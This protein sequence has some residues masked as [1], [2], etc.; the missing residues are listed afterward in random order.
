MIRF[1]YGFNIPKNMDEQ[2]KNELRAHGLLPAHLDKRVLTECQAKG[3][4]PSTL[5]THLSPGTSNDVAELYFAIEAKVDRLYSMETACLDD[6]ADYMGLVKQVRD[7]LRQLQHKRMHVQ[8]GNPDLMDAVSGAITSV[9][10]VNRDVLTISDY[11]ISGVR[12][13]LVVYPIKLERHN[14]PTFLTRDG[15]LTIN[16]IDP[17]PADI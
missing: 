1:I 6:T 10:G 5:E 3:I 12:P 2:L 7:D 11:H 13:N 17:D 8:Y 16:G 15:I 14:S 9:I 4:D